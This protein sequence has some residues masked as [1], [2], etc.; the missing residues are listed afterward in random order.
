M[1]SVYFLLLNKF[2]LYMDKK[3]R[4]ADHALQFDWGTM[5]II[6][7]ATGKDATNPLEG[8][9]KIS[10][11][12]LYILYGG[13]CRVEDNDD[14]AI[15]WTIEQVKK[16]LKAFSFGEVTQVVKAFSKTLQVDLGEENKVAEQEEKK[17]E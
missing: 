2:I 11:Q 13:L 14:K 16:V 15:S 4:I 12:A 9:E 7:S 6:A 1:L 5:E 10:E 3:V 17:S 8:I